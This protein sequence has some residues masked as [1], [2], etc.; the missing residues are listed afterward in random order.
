M[1]NF[2]ARFFC[3]TSN[4]QVYGRLKIMDL[5]LSLHK[6]VVVLNFCSLSDFDIQEYEFLHA[7]QEGVNITWI[8][9]RKI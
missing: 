7:A 3:D 8:V 6:S 4:D 9:P 5:M 2:F 1:Y